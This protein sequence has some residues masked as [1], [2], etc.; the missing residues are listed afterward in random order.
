MITIR[1]LSSLHGLGRR[2]AAYRA[3]MDDPSSQTR[4]AWRRGEV[5]RRYFDPFVWSR[6]TRLILLG[7]IAVVAVIVWS[8]VTTADV[9]ASLKDVTVASGQISYTT[10]ST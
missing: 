9:R 4:Q 2:D 7:I 10:G 8:M 3:R 1:A 6:K 5:S